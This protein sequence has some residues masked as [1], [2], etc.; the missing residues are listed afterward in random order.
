MY[1]TTSKKLIENVSG[2]FTLKLYS[3]FNK[4]THKKPIFYGWGL[5]RS[6]IKAI[7]LSR[8]YNTSF[9]LFEDG[10]IR[11]IGLG[12]HNSPTFSIN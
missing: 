3:I 2:F 9:I 6:G 8:K 5:K 11:S 12:I 7:N 4:L 10:F 1:Y